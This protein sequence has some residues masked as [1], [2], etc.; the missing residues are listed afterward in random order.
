[1]KYEYKVVTVEL[2]LSAFSRAKVD[3]K[4][5]EEEINKHGQE[6]WEL[7]SAVPNTGNGHVYSHTLYFK[8]SL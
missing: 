4:Q 3:S 2:N 6:G 7:V 1:M 5:I 8:R